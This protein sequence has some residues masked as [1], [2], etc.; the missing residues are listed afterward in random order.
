M[1]ATAPPEGGPSGG[2]VSAVAIAVILTVTVVGAI[3]LAIAARRAAMGGR[4]SGRSLRPYVDRA[5]RESG[6]PTDAWSEA[7]R[8]MPV[9]PRKEDRT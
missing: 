3:M 4:D 8:R 7:G 9:P 1:L 5:R 6:L 2:A